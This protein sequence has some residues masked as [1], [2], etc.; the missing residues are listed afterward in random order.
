MKNLL[1]IFS[2]LIISINLF[3]QTTT[4]TGFNKI[5]YYLGDSITSSS[6]IRGIAKS[7]S[8]LILVINGSDSLIYYKLVIAKTDKSGNIIKS[9]EFADDTIAKPTYPG[10]AIIIDSDSN[11]IVVSNYWY[12]NTNFWDGF[13]VKLNSNLDTLWTLVFNLPDSLAGCSNVGNFLTAIKE[14][15]DK[16]YIISGNY[17]KNCSEDPNDLRTYL[18]KLDKFG[19]V[20]WCKAYNNVKQVYDIA[21]TEDSSFVFN[22]TY[23]GYAINKYNKNGNYIWKVDPNNLIHLTSMDITTRGSYIVSASPY[24]YGE[25]MGASLWGIDVVKLNSTDGHIIW[26]KQYVTFS[27]FECPTLNQNFKI[28]ILPNNDIIIAGT[29]TVMNF[30][31]TN[32]GTKGIMLKLNSNGD[33][34]WCRYY[35]IRKFEDQC[36]FN[37]LLLTD[38]GGFLAVGY[39]LP[40]DFS[41]NYGAWLVKM[42][43]LGF[44]PGAETMNIEQLETM[45]LKI[46]AYPNP[47]SNFANIQFE[48]VLKQD[49]ALDI[50]NALGQRIYQAFIPKLK[51]ETKV[52]L[53]D[54]ERGVFFFVLRNEKGIIGSGKFVK[55]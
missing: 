9:V 33:S 4:S 8:N 29:A 45:G 1:L 34:L 19:N 31:S 32:A 12:T 23:T 39:H 11:I 41:Y 10:N 43:S 27:S 49:L 15:L 42:D 28:D 22:D 47:A 2:L 30:D 36:Q 46:N 14:T 5:E 17:S 55:E 53:R 6:E 37:D 52:D 40:G 16:N 51:N 38:D 13:V 50:Y 25:D 7:D 18:L 3:S 26:N 20:I 24:K 54:F 21:I 48:Q 44:A 35:G